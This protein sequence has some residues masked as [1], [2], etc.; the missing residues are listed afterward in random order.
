MNFFKALPKKIKFLIYFTIFI[1]AFFL[2]IKFNIEIIAEKTVG[3]F[4]KPKVKIENIDVSFKGMK[5]ENL[6]LI[7]DKQNILVDLPSIDVKYSLNSIVNKS[8]ESLLIEN[9]KIFIVRDKEGKIN[10]NDFFKKKEKKEK[11]KET[12]EIKTEAKKQNKS[13]KPKYIP[14]SKLLINNLEINFKDEKLPKILEKKLENININ[15][16]SSKDK[17]IKANLISEKN[18]EK[19]KINFENENQEFL[20]HLKTEGIFL[21]E[22][23]GQYISTNP[24][25]KYLGGEL[26]IDLEISPLQK[27]GYVKFENGNIEHNLLKDG[28]KN[29]NLDINLSGENGDLKLIFDALG[30]K[31]EISALYENEELKSQIIFENINKINLEKILALKNNKINL[32]KI[33]IKKIFLD[34]NYSLKY[35][36]KA[37]FK[38]IPNTLEINSL[39][40]DDISA[41]M[42]IINGV[43]KIDEAQILFNILDVN[44]KFAVFAEQ[45]ENIV[46]V[47][48]EIKTLSEDS[49]IFPEL[50]LEILAD[51][52]K[53]TIK[54]DIKLNDLSMNADYDRENKNIK[55]YNKDFYIEKLNEEKYPKGEGKL[56]LSFY[57]FKNILDFKIQDEIFKIIS[58]NLQTEKNKNL[59]IKGQYN[60]SNKDLFLDYLANDFSL[61]KK[62]KNKDISLNLKSSGKIYKESNKLKSDG[63]L[64][65]ANLSYDVAKIKL[66]QG[67]YFINLDKNEKNINFNG[68]L[69]NLSYKNYFLSNF[70]LSLNYKN[71]EIKIIKANNEKISINGNI[72][73]NSNKSKIS[74]IIENLENKDIGIDNLSFNVKDVKAEL[75]GDLKNPTAFLNINDVRIKTLDYESK[76]KGKVNLKN[77]KINVT[78]L[79]L[80]DNSLNASYNLKQKI[81]NATFDIDENLGKFLGNKD[82]DYTVKGKLNVDGLLGNLKTKFIA[83]GNGKF[84]DK[85]LPNLF[86][87]L[88]YK[89]NEYSGGIVNLKDLSLRNAQD[90]ILLNWLGYVNLKEKN[91]NIS[92]NNKLDI[93]K[94]KN[95]L[96]FD[97]NVNGNIFIKSKI[98]GNL[99]N[100][101]YIL[102][103]NS[104]DVSIKNN[105]LDEIKIFVEGN[106]KKLDLKEFKFSYLENNLFGRGFYDIKNKDYNFNLYS[107]LINLKDIN[108]NL[109]HKKVKDIL[110]T[111]Q[112]S[113]GI[114]KQG[115]NG[116][117]KVSDAGFKLENENINLK[118]F[119]SIIDI[120][121]NKIDIKKFNAKLND[122][123]L[124]LNAY[125]KIP[126]DFK[127]ILG[128]LDYFIN[129]N[130]KNFNYDKKD[131]AKLNLNSKINMNN[132][133]VIGEILIDKATVYDIPNDYKSLWSILKKKFSKDKDSEEKKQI[134]KEE[135]KEKSKKIEKILK[136]LDYVDLKVKTLSPIKLD[137]DDFNI[138]VGELKGNFETD[139]EILGTKG[140]FYILGNAE[141]LDGIMYV[142]TNK[143]TLERALLSF[144]DKR[145]YIPEI[146]PHI[147]LETRVNMDE[148]ELNFNVNGKMKKLVYSLSSE[149]GSEI[150]SLNSLFQEKKENSFSWEGH[151]NKLFVKFMKNIIAGQAIEIAF[152]RLTKFAK[153]TFNLSKLTIKPEI[154]IYDVNG[155]TTDKEK[156]DR[157][158][159]V[160]D[161]GAK[162]ELE[163]N[164]YRDKIF[165]YSSAKIDGTNK[166]ANIQT[167]DQ[168]LG[169]KEYDVGLEYRSKDGKSIGFGI[170]TFPDRYGYENKNYKKRNYHIDFKIRK[171]YNDFL[172]IFSF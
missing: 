85:E 144:N 79:K 31:N 73:P 126:N 57:G 109:S 74:L 131:V 157:G 150:G 111:V 134:K 56:N 2:L 124:S 94:L 122:G 103:I 125:A 86:L 78:Q 95:Y 161:I 142:N 147:F 151:N 43:K 61:N 47:K 11:S 15:L 83:K 148:D 70:D 167:T 98:A 13:Y 6:K 100:V 156:M 88:D 121:E 34:F 39:K 123:D 30:K 136:K 132:G 16:I 89:A 97:K 68:K 163:K 62:Y 36:L 77:Q 102:D 162:L 90:E 53:K 154:V 96:N 168:K 138:V 130:L 5:I 160:Y 135:K 63:N 23:I 99:E 33:D 137:I 166:K 42:S 145:T 38:V 108:K 114:D 120:K 26:K 69:N 104:N 127:N 28:I 155:R 152:G 106:K 37:D 22:H 48:S 40:I 75:K 54:S 139:L 140:K 27:K 159:Q 52:S 45:R 72:K 87:D 158:L 92:S 14:I 101:N 24:D 51:M 64:E 49:N 60:F 71:D 21:D 41:K 81:Y 164:L 93:K 113:L 107:N 143:F 169:I 19:F 35:G 112:I 29:I 91:L 116:F 50:N 170:G 7:D 128:N 80:N 117:L 12:K 1:V 10:F 165:M 119:N 149:K 25:I 32:E 9:P 84:K 146:N 82:L 110:G 129:F 118:N 59:N 141:I 76:L 44:Q 20:I 3:L 172:E 4:L 153:K 55:I 171:K 133:K 66:M 115:L 17:G 105:K 46:D 58:L 18:I 67:N 65:Y 8:I